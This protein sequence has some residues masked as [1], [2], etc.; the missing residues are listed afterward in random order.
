MSSTGLGPGLQQIKK[1][2]EI[3]IKELK[4]VQLKHIDLSCKA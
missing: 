4:M 3:D 2:E 1:G